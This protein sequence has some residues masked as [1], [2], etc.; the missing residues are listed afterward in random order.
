LT[1]W[2]I[3]SGAPI[4]AVFFVWKIVVE[5]KGG[6][7]EGWTIDQFITYQVL[8]SLIF[9]I[10]TPWSLA[11]SITNEI[12]LGEMNAYLMRPMHYGVYC[13][14]RY[15]GYNS[16]FLVLMVVPTATLLLI[17]NEYLYFTSAANLIGMIAAIMVGYGIQFTA[18]FCFAMLAFWWD[19]VTSVFF[20]YVLIARFA[21][22]E[23]LPLHL[24][25]D[26]LQ[27]VFQW[28]PF[29]NIAS[30]PVRTYMGEIGPQAYWLGMLNGV[31]WVVVLG[32]LAMLLWRRGMKKYGAYGG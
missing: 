17:L 5:T 30:F 23:T 6:V 1:G 2:A 27:G 22:G 15:A 29:P 19:E 8:A 20:A 28:T 10:N 16:V 7:L 18:T 14:A 13:L 26:W 12:R 4:I 24:L 32:F 25:P 21:A 9:A 3:L 31:V 11:M